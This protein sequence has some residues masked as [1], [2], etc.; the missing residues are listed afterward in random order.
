MTTSIGEPIKA[1]SIDGAIVR[2]ALRQLGLEPMEGSN[3]EKAEIWIAKD[4]QPYMIPYFK[5]GD[6]DRF[7]LRAFEDVI[8][9]LT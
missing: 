5:R 4:G 8:D 6:K 1:E 2:E 3:N 9:K 7:L